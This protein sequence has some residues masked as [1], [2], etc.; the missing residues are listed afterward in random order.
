MQYLTQT[1]TQTGGIATAQN[2]VLRNTYMMLA[3]TMV[4]TI[5]GAFIGISI[6]LSFMAASPIMSSLLMFGAMMGMLFAVSALRNSVWG[7]AAL[8]GFTFIAAFSSARS[9]KS[10]CT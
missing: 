6:D 1:A 5:I 2:K 3:L 9:C 8:L 7:I 4:P 10:R